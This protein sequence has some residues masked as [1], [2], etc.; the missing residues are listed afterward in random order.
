ML[1]FR[2][3]FPLLLSA[4][5]SSS[6]SVPPPLFTTASLAAHVSYLADDRLEGRA[7]GTPGDRLATD[8]IADA[9][10]TAGAAPVAESWFQ[11]VTGAIG[12]GA[13]ESR[14]VVGMVPGRIDPD[15][16]VL[17]VAHHDGQGR[18]EADASGDDIC[19]GAVDNASGVAIL[20]EIARLFAADPPERS[21]IFLA[22]AAE[23]RGFLGSRAFIAD[24]P[25][26]L[27]SIR[28]VIGVDT[29]AAR[30]YTR[31][32]AILGAGLTTLDPLVRQAAAADARRVVKS[33]GA[34]DFYARSDQYAFAEAGIPALFV[35]GLFAPGEGA[36]VGSPYARLRYHRPADQADAGIDYSGAIADA[37]TIYRLGRLIAD[38]DAEPRWKDSSPFQ[39]AP[40]ERH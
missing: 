14:N 12:E 11:P 33:S 28:A 23:E 22:S 24:P 40:G 6:V 5:V 16:Y 7:P 31:D 25:V 4:C 27:M 3:A 2:A 19:N 18:C 38:A 36:F 15:S 39:R 1:L 29:L 20:I 21:V 9:L 10:E 32:V 8:Y 34:Q 17:Y 37:A 35:S 30:G 26:P 13:F